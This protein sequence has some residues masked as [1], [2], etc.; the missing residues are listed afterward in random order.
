MRKDF[1]EILHNEME[2]HYEIVVLTGD[3]GFGVLDSIRDALPTRFINCGAAEGGMMGMAVGL[4]LSGKIPV[5]YSI[6]PFAI[7]RPA[8]IIRLYL[9][10]EKIP[11]KI[12]GAGRDKDYSHDGPSHDATDA[13][14]LFNIFSNIVCF[15][16]EQESLEE[17]VKYFLYND[18]PS[19][20]SLRR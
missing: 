2:K 3:L 12:V 8:E 14:S 20:I 16:P 10:G 19:F 17:S 9:N 11:V 15:Y 13:K 4:A 7:W 6:T 5:V 1:A 18:K